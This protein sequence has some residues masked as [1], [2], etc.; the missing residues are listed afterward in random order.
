MRRALFAAL[1]IGLVVGTDEKKDDNKKDLDHLKGNWTIVSMELDGKTNEGAI[2]GKFSF[3]GENMRIQIKDMEH[4]GTF[5]L[6]TGKKPKQ[7]NVTPAD[8]PE[9]DKV[10][11]GIYEL[12]KDELKICI[13]HDSEA[14]RPKEFESKEGSHHLLVK[15]KREK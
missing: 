15:L 8:G 7:I 1:V 13:G 10:L 6:D 9:K 2:D 14:A 5:K 12:A 4:K 11:E 3:D